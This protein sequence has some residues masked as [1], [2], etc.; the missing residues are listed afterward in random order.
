M[1]NNILGYIISFIL[2]AII[3][4]FIS[5]C[6]IN[7]VEGGHVL[8]DNSKSDLT[9]NTMQGAIDELYDKVNYGNAIASNVLADKTVL[10][11]GKKVVGSM[12]NNGA[13]G[14]TLNPGGSYTIPAG[15][16]SGGTVS[17]NSNSGTYTATSRAASIDMGANNTYRYVN[18]SSVPNTNSGTYTYATNSTGGTVDLGSTNTYRYVNATNVYN[19]GKIDGNIGYK[20]VITLSQGVNNITSL[21]SLPT[22]CKNIYLFVYLVPDDSSNQW[23]VNCT[24]MY[25]SFGNNKGVSLASAITLKTATSQLTSDWTARWAVVNN[26]Y[27]YYNPNGNSITATVIAIR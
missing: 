25:Y 6:A 24:D 4:S 21:A 12:A 14:A 11:G 1:K 18:T 7:S 8:Y 27:Y 9:S 22:T 26:N 15:Y 17:A 13:T 19:Q 20:S 5:V 10:I 23:L 16:T 2:G 3:F